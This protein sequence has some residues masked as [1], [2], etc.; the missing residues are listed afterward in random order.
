MDIVGIE[1]DLLL[2]AIQHR[3]GYDF[4]Q[5]ARASIRR[6]L[7]HFLED[8]DYQ[9][10]SQLIPRL[11]YDR[12][13]FEQILQQ[14]SITVTEMFRDPS[15]FVAIKESVLPY[16]K[17]FPFVKI[18]LAGCST[19]EEA[20]SMAI[21]LKEEGLYDRCT[22]FATDFNE[23]ALKTAKEGIYD[24][25]NIKKSTFNYQKAEG[26]SSFSDYYFADY[27]SVIMKQ[28]LREN[29][30]FANH[31]LVTDGI[32]GEMHLV[33][34]RNVLIYFDQSLQN[35][36]LNLFSE[37]LHAKGFLC[38]GNR[39]SIRF[40]EVGNQFEAINEKQRIFQKK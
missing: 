25:E 11:L 31:N 20:Y 39:E 21:F 28:E 33:L 10:I 23:K 36:V 34:C 4:R 19:G 13:F 26:H 37:S 8:S 40:S 6:R 35:K 5:Y 15:F 14:F 38:L 29:I 22:I 16:L 3:Y 27:D 32:F 24:L 30:T 9:T 12:P 7:L 2:E 1:I 18:W 17:T